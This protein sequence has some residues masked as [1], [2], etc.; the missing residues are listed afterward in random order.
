MST[1]L[2]EPHLDQATAPAQRLR[3]TM[4]AVRVSFMWLGVRKTLTFPRPPTLFGSYRRRPSHLFQPQPPRPGGGFNPCRNPLPIRTVLPQRTAGPRLMANPRLRASHTK[5]FLAKPV[6]R[7]SPP[8]SS[9]PHRGQHAGLAQADQ[10]P[11]RLIPFLRSPP[12]KKQRETP[13][14]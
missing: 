7:T 14:P 12:I 3:T 9:R 8:S 6:G 13:C 2:D 5:R 1:V 11:G 10:G 4:A